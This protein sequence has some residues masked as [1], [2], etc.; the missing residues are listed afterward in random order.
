[1]RL[2]NL[3]DAGMD[4]KVWVKAAREHGKL[5]IEQLAAAMGRSKA[6][7]G[8]WE[9]GTTRPSYAQIKKIS[10]ITGWPMPDTEPAPS[11]SELDAARAKRWPYTRIDY[12]KLAGL[13]GTD[14]RNLENAI[15][16]AAGDLDLDIRVARR[17]KSASA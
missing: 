11:M 1:M 7:A 10:E 16:A 6:A 4:L 14:A 3:Y 15:L 8:F 9:T 12:E 2:G 17:G 5:T 13:R